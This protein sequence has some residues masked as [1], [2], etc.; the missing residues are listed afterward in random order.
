MPFILKQ[1]ETPYPI[2]IGLLGADAVMLRAQVNTYTLQ[3]FGLERGIGVG[4]VWRGRYP[5]KF[6]FAS[7]AGYWRFPM[8]GVGWFY[9]IRLSASVGQS[10]NPSYK[11]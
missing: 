3:P 11:A 5:R 7:T 4:G 8:D 2:H 6:R 10:S 9:F 1:N